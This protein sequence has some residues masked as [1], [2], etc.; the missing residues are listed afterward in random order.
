M[1]TK[2]R[3]EYWAAY[4]M[5]IAGGALLAAVGFGLVPNWIPIGMAV[6]LVVGILRTARS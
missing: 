4:T 3:L 2:Q 1:T 5:G 6:L